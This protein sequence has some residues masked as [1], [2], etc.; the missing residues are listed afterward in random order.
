VA[1]LDLANCAPLKIRVVD[2]DVVCQAVLECRLFE[3]LLFIVAFAFKEVEHML[4]GGLKEGLAL[5]QLVNGLVD[6]ALLV[7]TLA[8]ADTDLSPEKVWIALLYLLELAIASLEFSI[9]HEDQT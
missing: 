3:L 2:D 8:E 5:R 7:E 6:L 4:L 9:L 1:E